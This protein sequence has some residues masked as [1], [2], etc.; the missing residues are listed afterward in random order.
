MVEH[1]TTQRAS[2]KLSREE[3]WR[4]YPNEWVVLIDLDVAD[5]KV[6]GGVVR[7]HGPDRATLREVIKGLTTETA[8]FWTGPRTAS[9]EVPVSRVG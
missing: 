3:I 2:E 4:R 5:M 6:R 9:G 8:V 7:A 1:V